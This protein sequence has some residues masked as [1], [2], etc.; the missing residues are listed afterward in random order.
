[1]GWGVIEWALKVHIH[2]SSVA[3]QKQQLSKFYFIFSH[4]EL[5]FSIS[6]PMAKIGDQYLNLLF[7]EESVNFVRNSVFLNL[8]PTQVSILSSMVL[9]L[10]K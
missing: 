3:L 9:I 4:T 10:I 2:F 7:L 8:S 5:L 6:S 1:M